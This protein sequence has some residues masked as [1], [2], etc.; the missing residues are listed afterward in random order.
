LTQRDVVSAD[1][2][3]TRLLLSRVSDAHAMLIE[4]TR[5][6]RG[7]LFA[8]IVRDCDAERLLALSIDDG[9]VELVAGI[10]RA[11]RINWH[12]SIG[13]R[14]LLDHAMRCGN[15]AVVNVVLD[16]LDGDV[17][18]ANPYSAATAPS[19]RPDE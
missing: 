1:N 11:R 2:P 19:L 15:D 14:T 18:A 4:A 6:N 16:H 10:A 12:S 17:G 9:D 7:D 5:V 8:A 13:G 3:V